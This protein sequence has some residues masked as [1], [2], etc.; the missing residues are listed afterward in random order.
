M[1]AEGMTLLQANE[2]AGWQT[3]FHFHLHV[4]PRHDNDELTF[5]WPVQNPPPQELDRLAAMVRQTL[6]VDSNAV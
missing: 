1:Q 5:S 2:K 4:V 3:V 6:E